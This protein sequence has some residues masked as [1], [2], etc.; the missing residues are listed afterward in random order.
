MNPP[1]RYQSIATAL[2][3]GAFD[4]VD[5]LQRSC[6]SEDSFVDFIVVPRTT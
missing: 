5:V 1:Y 6:G 4:G 3:Q 2:A